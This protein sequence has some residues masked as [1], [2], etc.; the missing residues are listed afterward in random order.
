MPN[1][2]ERKARKFNWNCKKRAAVELLAEDEL[3]DEQ[4]CDRV[5]IGRTSLWEWRQNPEFAAELERQQ[6][7][8]AA[9]IRGHGICNRTTRLRGYQDRRD[10][11]LRVIHQRGADPKLKDVPGGDTGLI[12]HN[13]KGVGKGEDF[14]LIDLYEVDVALLRELRETEKQAAI[15]LGEWTEKKEHSG[16]VAF[17]PITFDGEKTASDE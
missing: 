6:A 10:R 9:R 11:M 13:V 17:H 5:G 4:L 1:N 8:V 3:T 16:A 12:V 14:Q 2:S 7:G 15:E